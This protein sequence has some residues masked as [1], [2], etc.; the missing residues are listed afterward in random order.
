MRMAIVVFEIQENTRSKTN[1]L[2]STRSQYDT[3]WYLRI[4]SNC[5]PT[6]WQ[7]SVNLYKNRKETAIYRRRNNT[8]N[9]IA[10]KNKQNRKRTSK[11]EKAYKE[12]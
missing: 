7:W 12:Y 8:R 9:N 11:Q 1:K 2:R 10:T 5:V 6:R 3:I 4:Y